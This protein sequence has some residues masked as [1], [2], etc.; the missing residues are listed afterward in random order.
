MKFSFFVLFLFVW[1]YFPSFNGETLNSFFQD[2]PEFTVK[3]IYNYLINLFR[4]K[5]KRKIFIFFLSRFEEV[6]MKLDMKSEK[7]L[8]RELI[9]SFLIIKI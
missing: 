3:K 4:F 2:L 9:I 6:I 8:K 1:S 5:I 7:H